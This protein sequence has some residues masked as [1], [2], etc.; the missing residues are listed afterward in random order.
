MDWIKEILKISLMIYI[1]LLLGI[2]I[3]YRMGY[4]DA[5][6]IGTPIEIPILKQ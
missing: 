6:G 2:W 1:P 4:A 3:G 5:R